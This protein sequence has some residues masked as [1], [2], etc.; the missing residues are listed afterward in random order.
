MKRYQILTLMGILLVGLSKMALA[1][2]W[3]DTSYSY[4]RQIEISIIASGIHELEAGYSC[5]V[6]LD[7]TDGSRF[8]PDGDDLRVIYWN[9]SSNVELHRDVIGPNSTNTKVWFATQRSIFNPAAGPGIDNNY[10]LYY[11]NPGASNPPANLNNVYI[12]GDDFESG[13]GQWS[14]Y[15]GQVSTS[16]DVAVRGNKSLKIDNTRNST[17][18]QIYINKSFPSTTI[19]VDYYLQGVQTTGASMTHN[20]HQGDTLPTPDQAYGHSSTISWSQ[21]DNKSKMEYYDGSWH[22]FYSPLQANYWYHLEE[23]FYFN[24]RKMMIEVDGATKVNDETGL[25]LQPTSGVK[26]FRFWAYD[27]EP[28]K[29]YIDEIRIRK[30][31][32]PEPTT[33]PGTEE[34]QGPSPLTITTTSLPSGTVG[35]AYSQTVSATGGTTPYT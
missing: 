15:N 25:I 21:W 2:D 33:S 32:D 16:S 14:Y 18:D 28:G 35:T 11:G 19:K 26:Y 7:T 30:Y 1:A 29:F 9:G 4:R 31:I 17:H 10:Y 24:S 8:Q 13:L 20:F 23:Y 12:F 3:W 27:G 22:S 5:S 34:S 6:T